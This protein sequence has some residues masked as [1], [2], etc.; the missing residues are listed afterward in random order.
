MISIPLNN[1]KVL[2][3]RIKTKMVNIKNILLL[4]NYLTI[5]KYKY[6][7]LYLYLYLFPFLNI[8]H[9]KKKKNIYC[10]HIK[11]KKKKK[12]KDDDKPVNIKQLSQQELSQ[13]FIELFLQQKLRN[14]HKRNIQKNNFFIAT[15]TESVDQNINI[16][17]PSVST[18][19]KS[20]IN[21]KTEPLFNKKRYIIYI[22]SIK[23]NIIIDKNKY[24]IYIEL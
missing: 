23:I 2:I 17:S 20:N 10:L 13:A 4:I 24:Y 16:L 8:Y 9:L 19:S 12:K 22:F 14:I 6:I 5:I 1:D 3:F 15:N 7:Y 21:I 18:I 11:I